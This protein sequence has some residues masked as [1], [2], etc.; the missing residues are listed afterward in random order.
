MRKKII[1]RKKRE[2]VIEEATE[3]ITPEPIKALVPNRGKGLRVF[4][5]GKKITINEE[6]FINQY[7]VDLN[8]LKASKRAGLSANYGYKVLG[9]PRVW[10]E[11]EGRLN[12]HRKSAR[13]HRNWIIKNLKET[14]VRCMSATPKMDR[15]SGE[16]VNWEFKANETI[17][18][19]ELMAKLEGFV[20][21]RVDGKIDHNHKIDGE[22]KMYKIEIERSEDRTHKVIEILND[23]GAFDSAKGN[24]KQLSDSEVEQIHTAPANS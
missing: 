17:R 24:I 11:I 22:V 16:M 6:L 2:E 13:V 5:P 7:M 8:A 12:E 9:R 1:R 23:A 19:L 18:A 21:L 3:E 10:R 20:Q 4:I 14:I 15:V